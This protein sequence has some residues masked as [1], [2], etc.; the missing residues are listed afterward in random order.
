MNGL[1]LLPFCPGSLREVREVRALR[2]KDQTLLFRFV[3]DVL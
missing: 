1:L 2:P 3:V